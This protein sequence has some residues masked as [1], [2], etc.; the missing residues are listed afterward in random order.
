MTGQGSEATVGGTAGLIGD[1]LEPMRFGVQVDALGAAEPDPM[2]VTDGSAQRLPELAL[3][4]RSL[5]LGIERDQELGCRMVD[6][7]VF[8]WDLRLAGVHSDLW[9]SVDVQ[10]NDA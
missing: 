7:I 3:V 2:R 8:G 9:T 6:G 10:P 4:D 5:R 1:F